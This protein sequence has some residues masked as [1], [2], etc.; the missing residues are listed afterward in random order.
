MIDRVATP[1]AAGLALTAC[2][3]G[4]GGPHEPARPP[5][6]TRLAV[7]RAADAGQAAPPPALPATA[8]AMPATSAGRQLAW[9]LG[10]LARGGQ[11]DAAVLTAHFDPVFL[12]K[13]PPDKL[14]PA[15]VQLAGHLAAMTVDAVS[16]SDDA[17]AVLR[18]A[19]PE[20]R[21]ALAVRV[22]PATR[23]IVD[24]DVG[25]DIRAAPAATMAE[26]I[27]AVSALAP[28]AQ[29]LVAELDRG[30]CRPLYQ[31]NPDAELAIASAFKL[32]VL[33]GLTDR[34]LAGNA[35]WTDEVIVR[36]DWKSLPS[37]ITQDDPAGT[38]LTVR[39]LAERMIS[40]SDNTAADILLY[41]VGRQHVEAAVRAAHHADPALDTPFLATRELFWLKM[42]A[43][44]ADVERYLR[45]APAPRRAFLD[46]LAGKR[47]EGRLAQFDDWTTPRHIDRIEW[48]ASVADLCRLMA[49]LWSRAQQPA[50][51]PLLD[52]LGRNP[53]LSADQV[54]AW[55]YAGFKGGSEPGVATTTWLLRRRSDDR[56][57]V[58][59]LGLNGPA[60]IDEGAVLGAAHR[61]VDLLA[62]EAP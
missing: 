41:T 21:F 62:A 5:P 28:R 33:L 10:V 48:F 3:L 55:S 53:G 11:V 34:I 54:P 49:A 46:H 16:S 22:D 32:Y 52:V 9:L 20:G 29:L 14:A 50:A 31:L 2:L 8:A 18:G 27:A 42:V 6:P 59:S 61:V 4:C 24:L 57:F 17:L 43:A 44:P 40:I 51:A 26:A 56:W 47:P 36:D 1:R 13:R 35:A 12:A 38:R 7:A 60:A 25:P 39:T 19:A 23:L 45:L 37:G 15:L 30:T 58:V